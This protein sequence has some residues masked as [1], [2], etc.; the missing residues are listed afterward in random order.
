MGLRRVAPGLPVAGFDHDE[1][2]MVEAKKRGALTVAASSPAEAAQGADVVVV[3]VPVDRIGESLRA[4]LPGLGDDAVVTDVGSAKAKVVEEA[5]A[6]M[7][8]RFV[9]GHPMAGSERHGM[10][11]ADPR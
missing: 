2:A 10:S 8:G 4:L 1:E 7:G 11:A 6:I 5:Q 9:G 3:A